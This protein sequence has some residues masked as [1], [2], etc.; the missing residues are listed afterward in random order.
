VKG[1]TVQSDHKGTS[2]AEE[3]ASLVPVDWGLRRAQTDGELGGT[4][5][6]ESTRR[7]CLQSSI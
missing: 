5:L 1:L 2:L 7:L 3:M 4:G 6:R